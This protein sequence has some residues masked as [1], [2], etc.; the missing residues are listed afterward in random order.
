M[1]AARAAD[2]LEGSGVSKGVANIKIKELVFSKGH[3]PSFMLQSHAAVAKS[4]ESFFEQGRV[5]FCLISA[6]KG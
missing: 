5:M 4:I 2:P 1:H 6:E 3:S